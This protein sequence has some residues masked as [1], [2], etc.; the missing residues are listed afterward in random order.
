LVNGAFVPKSFEAMR[1]LVVWIDSTYNCSLRPQRATK[2][3]CSKCPLIYRRCR[4][5]P[6]KRQMN[7]FAAN[8]EVSLVRQGIGLYEGSNTCPYI[9]DA[10]RAVRYSTLL[11][12]KRDR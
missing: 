10:Q 4:N 2:G 3:G 8:C 6:G 12:I 5:M 9:T 1:L 7:D 11:R